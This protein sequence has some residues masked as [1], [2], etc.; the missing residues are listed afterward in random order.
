MLIMYNLS[1]SESFDQLVKE[2]LYYYYSCFWNFCTRY[3]K[4]ANGTFNCYARW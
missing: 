4:Y 1:L 3:A 2:L